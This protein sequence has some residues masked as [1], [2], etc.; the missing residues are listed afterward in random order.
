MENWL[1][2]SRLYAFLFSGAARHHLRQAI[3]RNANMS[4]TPSATTPT[5]DE[6][7]AA[8]AATSPAFHHSPRGD[9]AE[10]W[11]HHDWKFLIK[12]TKNFLVYIDKEN[13]L[14]WET[15]REYDSVNEAADP[16]DVAKRAALMNDCAVLETT[17]CGGL[18]ASAIHHFKRLIGEAIAN[19][20][21]GNYVA[22]QKMVGVAREYVQRRSEET[23]RGWYLSASFKA[24]LPVIGFGLALWVFRAPVIDLLGIRGLWLLLSACAGAGGALFSVITRSGKLRFD[25]SAGKYLHVLEATSRIAA[26]AFSG[27]LAALAVSADIILSTLTTGGRLHLIMI[28]VALAAGAGERL[29]TS[30]ISKFDS[31]PPKLPP[32]AGDSQKGKRE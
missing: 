32:S 22:A 9:Y 1:H 11:A 27:V 19:S 13:N 23:S 28:L 4:D 17:P 30:I 10:Q 12:A 20:L 2:I 8:D 21:D 25:C 6:A 14:D 31:T 26:G 29:A 7:S 18:D 16:K 5:P 15:S 24:G 3:S